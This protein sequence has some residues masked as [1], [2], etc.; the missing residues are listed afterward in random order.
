MNKLIAIVLLALLSG[1]AGF[2]RF[3][4]EYAA[5]YTVLKCK[6]KVV[7]PYV[8]ELADSLVAQ[9]ESTDQADI[10]KLLLNLG[11]PLLEIKAVGEAYRKCGA[12]TEVPVQVVP[13]NDGGV[14]NQ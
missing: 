10:G 13:E 5:A 9:T 12:P 6:A 3:N 4:P 1:C 7:T 2:L 8:G 14:V 11:V